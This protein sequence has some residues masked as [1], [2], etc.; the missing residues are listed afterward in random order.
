[1]GKA[2]I[3]D[4]LNKLCAPFTRN[5]SLR[6]NMHIIH[7]QFVKNLCIMCN[8]NAGIICRMELR[9]TLGHNLY[10]IHVKT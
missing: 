4:L 8:N 10:S 1:M 5:L 2:L 3:I 7:L 6:E 9:Y